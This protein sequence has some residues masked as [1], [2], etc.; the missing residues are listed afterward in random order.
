MQD[1]TGQCVTSGYAT[2]LPIY[3]FQKGNPRYKA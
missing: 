1:E 3:I 2:I